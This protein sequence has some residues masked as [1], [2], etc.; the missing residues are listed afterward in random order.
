M[1]KTKAQKKTLCASCPVAKVADILGDS[2]ILLIVRDLLTGPKRFG[3]LEES[4]TGISSRTL[5]LKLK[6]LDEK[7]I[8]T[9]KV[10]KESP[11]RVEYSL[12]TV[13]KYLQKIIDDMRTYGEKHL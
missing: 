13:G 10:F 12:T 7:K 8:I 11:P 6:F 5:T 2:V 1:L 4:L 3:D 9:R